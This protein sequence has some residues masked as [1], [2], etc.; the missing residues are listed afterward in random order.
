MRFCK[1]NIREP[2][3]ASNENCEHWLSTKCDE[4]A[5]GSRH[6]TDGRSPVNCIHQYS[7]AKSYFSVLNAKVSSAKQEYRW[8][9][10][11]SLQCANNRKTLCS[12]MVGDER[13]TVP[14]YSMQALASCP[15]TTSIVI[16][17]G[18][19]YIQPT[20]QQANA[21]GSSRRSKCGSARLF[22]LIRL[23]VTC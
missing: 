15:S 17:M 21:V 8:V 2:F 22:H 4:M 20:A 1:P 13:C 11:A 3:D 19:V 10:L 5:F 14:P 18:A 6:F 9:D 12:E 23:L 16:S 7:I